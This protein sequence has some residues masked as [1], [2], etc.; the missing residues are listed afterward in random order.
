MKAGASASSSTKESVGRDSHVATFAKVL[1]G[2]KQP[3]RGMWQR[4]D[5]FYAQLTIENPITGI[6][7]VKRVPLVDKDSNPVQTVA[8][9]MAELRRL[10]TKR[11]DNTLPVLGRTPRFVD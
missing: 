8:Q 2:R 4:N 9:A 11:A 3:I 1:D 5:R 10:Q 7:K 6:K